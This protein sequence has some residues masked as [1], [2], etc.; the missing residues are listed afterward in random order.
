LRGSLPPAPGMFD[1]RWM[2]FPQDFPSAVFFRSHFIEQI[3][4]VQRDGLIPDEDL[5]YVLGPWKKAGLQMLTKNLGSAPDEVPQAMVMNRF[6]R[7]GYRLWYPA[8]ILM[9]VGLRRS[10][11]GGFGSTIPYSSGGMG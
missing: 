3:V 11:V 2:V 8:M 10:N 1:N 6:T 4:V 7:Y 9:S 5:A